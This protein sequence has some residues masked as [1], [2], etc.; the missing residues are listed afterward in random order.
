MDAN[1]NII[2]MYTAY[3]ENIWTPWVNGNTAKLM[4][5]SDSYNTYDGFRCDKY[6]EETIGIGLE[7]VEIQLLPDDRSTSSLTSGSFALSEVDTGAHTVSPVLPFWTFDPPS[8]SLSISAGIAEHLFFYARL[9]DLSKP[10]QAKSIPNGLQVTIKGA[11][12]SAVFDGFFYIQDP[13]R[14]GGL[15]VNWSGSVT[16]GSTIDA[17][18][19]ITA[20]SG[21]RVLNATSITVH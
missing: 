2:E 1:D 16:E 19:T 15:R 6:E 14:I 17:T 5:T 8:V 3:D 11:L 12:I 21:E 7:G 4:L 20:S 13:Q 10:I 18:G 9:S